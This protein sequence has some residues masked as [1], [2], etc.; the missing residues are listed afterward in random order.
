MSSIATSAHRSVV[1]LVVVATL[2]AGCGSDDEAADSEAPDPSTAASAVAEPSAS[3]GDPTS[4]TAA[5]A[6]GTATTDP[7]DD[8]ASDPTA[9]SSEAETGGEIEQTRPVTVAGAPLTRLEGADDAIGAIA[10]T[11]DGQSFDGSEIVVGGPQD[12]PMMLVFLAHWC[13]HCNAEIPELVEL[14][15]AGSLPDDLDVVAISTSSDPSRDNYPPSEWLDEKGWPWPAMADD[16]NG[17]AIVAMG[18]SAFP[19]TVLLDA[20]GTV[21]ARRAGQATADET[22]QF[23]TDALA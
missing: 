18:G 7:A 17:S 3:D 5:D 15:E 11:I 22:L 12:G 10:P 14:E 9:S 2:V 21:L 16:E 6:D 13:P 4:D 23:I 1:T 19:F 8:A 20:D